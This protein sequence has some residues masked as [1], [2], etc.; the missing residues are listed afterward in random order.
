MASQDKIH[1][2][3]NESVNKSAS[4]ICANNNTEALQRA[5]LSLLRILN[6]SNV[7]YALLHPGDDALPDVSSDI[8]IIFDKI[9]GEI[10][11]PALSKLADEFGTVW[12]QSLHY[13][14]PYGYYYVVQVPT[15][16]G[17][18]YLQLDC[19]HDSVGINRYHLSSTFLL[20]G[21]EYDSA[22]FYRAS[23]ASETLYLTIKRALK[24]NASPDNVN[25]LVES[26]NEQADILAPL[27]S[28]CL[29]AGLADKV[30]SLCQ[31]NNLIE[32]AALLNNSS[33]TIE[34]QFLLSHPLRYLTKQVTTAV[35]QIKRFIRPTGLFI[36]LI[37]PDGCGKTT[38]STNIRSNMERCFRNVW[39]FHW[40][41]KLL[42]KLG[43]STPQEIDPSSGEPAAP[44]PPEK[45]KYNTLLSMIRFLYYLADFVLG[46][47]LVIYPKKARST[48][49]VGERYFAD[50]LVHPARYGFSLPNWFMRLCSHI[51]P[52][53]DVIILL[54]GD[55]Q[56]I[57]DRKPE[58]P[59]DV[60]RSQLGQYSK[61]IV[62]WGEHYTADT[63]QPADAVVFDIEQYFGQILHR[64]LSGTGVDKKLAFPRLGRPRIL[65]DPAISNKNLKKLYNPAS[66]LGQLSLFPLKYL[67]NFLRPILAKTSLSSS[68]STFPRSQ[69]DDVIKGQFDKQ[70]E[71]SIS[72]YLGNGGP[73]TKITAQVVCDGEIISY[74]K[75]AGTPVAKPLL[76]NE[77]NALKT[78]EA[79]ESI[80]VPKVITSLS[81]DGWDYLFTTA[82]TEEYVPSGGALTDLHSGLSET[83]FNS[84]TVNVTLQAF[85]QQHHLPERINSIGNIE[86]LINSKSICT[87]TIDHLRHHFLDRKLIAGKNHG[88]F[89]PW[90]ILNDGQSL[91]I[92]DWEYCENDTSALSDLIHFVRSQSQ[93]VYKYA[94]Q[95]TVDSILSNGII[96]DSATKLGINSYDIPYYAS[97]YFL[98]E[99]LRHAETKD[100]NNGSL[101]DEA[102]QISQIA[103]LSECLQT[104]NHACSISQMPRRVCVAAYAC[105]PDQGSEPGVGWNWIKLLSKKNQIWVFTKGNNKASVEAF[106]KDNPDHHIRFVFVDVPKWLSF[107]KKGQRGVRTYYYLWQIFAFLEA[108]RL[109]KSVNFELSHH[110]TFV[111]DWLWSFISLLPVPYIWGPIGSHPKVPSPLLPHSGAR[112]KETLR[113]S[114]QRAMRLLDPL[115]WLTALRA[116]KIIV[117]NKEIAQQF[118]LSLIAKDKCIVEGAIAHESENNPAVS[119]KAENFTVLY[120]GRFHHTKCPHLV[121]EAFSKACESMPDAQLVMIGRGPE[122][123]YLKSLAD[124]HPCRDS[125]VFKSWCTQA[126]VLEEMA[127]SH[128]FLF[129]SAEGGGMVVIE[130]MSLGLPV[131]C[132]DYGGPGAMVTKETGYLAPVS[133]RQDVVDSL[134]Q[135]LVQYFDD[136]DLL[137]QHSK[138]AVEHTLENLSWESKLDRVDSIYNRVAP[139]AVFGTAS[140]FKP[141]D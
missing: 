139:P 123:D 128:V 78:V 49:I 119:E 115:Y 81:V 74:V 45:A 2:L 65:I 30:I 125:I 13:D 75:M 64:R 26:I 15:N 112:F 97:L 16:D 91:Y 12:T 63:N 89:V 5:L 84:S 114:I 133:G 122:T 20:D 57:H 136:P 73:R 77:C 109:H 129:P 98:N 80:N 140:Q 106:V 58:L 79:V 19:L 71:L 59:V 44:A 41:P 104:I 33:S 72:Y 38:I 118:P 87:D 85:L 105:E 35:R 107:W 61:E 66:R 47:W 130:A 48:F 31:S 24:R 116:E 117:I 101:L 52:K 137:K 88:D 56:R 132:L 110:V 76:E 100:G 94:P 10:I 14:V 102:N 9:P 8:D 135:A 53:P 113:L 90:N 32:L 120:V 21:R 7:V 36:V 37:G 131:V 67:P 103:Y 17:F 28:E 46:Y 50:I 86:G 11:E 124:Q 29:G 82:P 55:P 42:P 99:I 111:N 39:R 68:F 27:L 18:A 54:S 51:V 22:G 43:K 34:K 127:R 83:I 62:H 25:T 121:I 141:Q 95:R 23:S 3:M 93:F 1:R 6:D 134:A 60:I 70:G 138:Y 69:A 126:E 4:D 108:R 40:R 92:F 96:S